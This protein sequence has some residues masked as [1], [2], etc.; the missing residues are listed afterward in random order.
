MITCALPRSRSSASL[1]LVLSVVIAGAVTGV[2]R[3]A[4]AIPPVL[5]EGTRPFVFQGGLGPAINLTGH[6]TQFKMEQVFGYHFFGTSEGPCL[7]G[8]LEESFGNNFFTF[9]IGPRFWWDIQPVAGLGLYLAPLA[10]LGYQ[11][12]TFDDGFLGRFRRSFTYHAFNMKF[13]F[14]VK[15]V[16]GDR[17]VVYFRP[18]SIDMFIQ[19]HFSARWDIMMGGGVTF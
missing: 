12:A 11:V 19:D 10:Q 1:L 17:G 18:F 4:E 14:E 13:G 7:G 2:S 9:Q 6:G 8:A 15:L 3:T 16:L 5:R